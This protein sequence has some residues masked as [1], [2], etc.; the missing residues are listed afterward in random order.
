MGKKRES[1]R[2]TVVNKQAYIEKEENDEN[3]DW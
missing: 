1:G 2:K 3:K